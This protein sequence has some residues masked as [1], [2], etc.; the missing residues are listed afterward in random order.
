MTGWGTGF[1]LQLGT[2]NR[3]A[4][5]VSGSYLSTSWMPQI[6]VWYHIVATHNSANNLN[7]L[8]VNG[9]EENKMTRAVAYEANPKTYIGVFYTSPSL[10]FNGKID[11]VRIY[12]TTLSA[13]EIQKLYAQG[14]NDHQD[15]I[16]SNE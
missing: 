4:A 14:S 16:A 15:L 9:K 3:I 7:I 2:D 12:S 8:Y 5:M 10:Y 11:N 13:Y 6:N 1:S